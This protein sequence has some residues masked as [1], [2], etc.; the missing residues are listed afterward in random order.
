MLSA[1]YSDNGK[2]GKKGMGIIMKKI[3]SLL[4]AGCLF[5]GTLC[6]CG[7]TDSANENSSVQTGNDSTTITIW[8]DKEDEVAEILQQ[9]L[10]TLEPDIHVTLEKKSD[11]TESLKMAGNNPNA[12][13]LFSK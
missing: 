8:H 9:K 5:V 4:M 10:A 12:A 6:G 1:Y 2:I 3:C 7:S 11:L 13:P